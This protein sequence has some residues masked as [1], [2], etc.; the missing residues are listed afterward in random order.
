[1]D[2]HYSAQHETKEGYVYLLTALKELEYKC[3]VY[4]FERN[5]SFLSGTRANCIT[6]NMFCSGPSVTFSPYKR[7][8][9]KPEIPNMD[10]FGSK[11]LKTKADYA[12]FEKMFVKYISKHQTFCEQ[13]RRMGNIRDGG[14]DICNDIKYRPKSPCLVYSFGINND[15]SFDEAME[16][17]YG[18]DV[19]SFDPSM[20]IG[21]HRHSKRIQFFR[22]GIGAYDSE[23]GSE[24][25]TTK[26]NKTWK[27]KRLQTIIRELNHENRR[28]DVLKLDI[29]GN[30]KDTLID[31]MKSGVLKNVVQLCLEFHSYYDIGA[32]RMLYDLGFRIFWTHQNPVAPFYTEVETFSHGNEVSFVN[33]NIP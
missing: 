18:C 20:G 32:S 11:D 29:E 23:S 33:I 10:P 28:I 24:N 30:E 9:S 2:I 5:W 16:K 21:D 13:V 27:L 3:R 19:Y 6:I 7:V 17:V 25:R 1:M 31:M 22:T 4:W 14:W 15:F 8:E 26:S 12:L